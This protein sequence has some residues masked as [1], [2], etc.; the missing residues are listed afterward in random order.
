MRG[1]NSPLFLFHPIATIK[2][3]KMKTVLSIIAVAA[4]FMLY[5]G[6]KALAESANTW[7]NE[8]FALQQKGDLA[9]AIKL[10]TRAVESNPMFAMAYQMRGAAHQQLKKYPQAISDYTMVITYGEPYFKA[11]GYYN[12][13]VVK[14]MTGA[15]ADAIPDFSQAIELDRKMAGAYFHRGISKSKI[16]DLAGRLED[17]RQAAR[18]GDLN[19]EAWLNTYYPDWKQP[20]LPSVPIDTVK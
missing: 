17:F 14:N 4:V 9:G 8:G 1:I 12:R 3:L 16:G 18:L 10:Y 6:S 20:Q 7:F 15:F 11:V 19:A 13:G 2:R 5:S